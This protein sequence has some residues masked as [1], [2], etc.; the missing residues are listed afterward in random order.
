M[1]DTK[2]VITLIILISFALFI[3]YDAYKEA[4]KQTIIDS[5]FEGYEE[6]IS[7]EDLENIFDDEFL[8]LIDET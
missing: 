8:D 7:D 2:L 3:S 6:D 5:F 1:K 4:Q